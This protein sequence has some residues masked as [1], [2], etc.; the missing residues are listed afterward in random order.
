MTKKYI[1]EI[2]KKQRNNKSVY[3]DSID[4]LRAIACLG[5][6]LMHIKANTDYQ[7]NGNYVFDKIIPSMTWFV[8]LFLM[9][10]G[11]GMCVGYL[12]KFQTGVINIEEFYKKRY[13]KV[14]PFFS[15]LILIDLVVEHNVSAIYEASI[16]IL[17][18]HGLLP[19]NTVSVIGVS[20]TLGVVFLFYLLFPAFS[21]IVKSK[22]RAWISLI[23]SLW[24]TFA[25]E[26]Y[27]FSNFFVAESFTPRHNFLYCC[28]MFIGG[29]IVYLYRVEIK[30]ICESYRW[31]VLI[32]C[33]LGLVFWNLIPATSEMPFYIMSLLMFSGWI[34]YAVGV[35]SKFLSSKP[36]K[37]LSGISL[38]MYLA[39]MVIFSVVK[40]L[41]LIYV[42]GD[43]GMGGW[44]SLLF[45]FVL[46]VIGLVCFI[47]CYKF[48]LFFLKVKI[49]QFRHTGE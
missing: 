43:T 4:G 22:K 14:L 46:T 26:K 15:M 45:A 48:V 29:A 5:I 41:H 47:Y 11:F 3:Y 35:K 19:N 39:Q 18:L 27:F 30:K 36:M 10:S 7:L 44:F 42:F 16:E 32:I 38:E 23:I 2:E 17:L 21:I 40:K 34:V 13:I 33:L 9:I 20:W 25:C 6:I 8:Y 12:E 24:V 49:R 28:P 37:F 1:N 31:L